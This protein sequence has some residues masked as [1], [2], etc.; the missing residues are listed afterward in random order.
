MA[1]LYKGCFNIPRI[2]QPYNPNR[3]QQH[4]RASL[5]PQI[6]AEIE[7][8][9]TVVTRNL[10]KQPIS[11]SQYSSLINETVKRVIEKR[12]NHHEEKKYNRVRK[13][14][15]Y[16]TPNSAAA[17]LNDTHN[18]SCIYSSPSPFEAQSTEFYRF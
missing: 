4:K 1:Y 8:A 15:R 7:A 16:R 12:K 10:A 14:I 13:I 5:D 17:A 11:D 9:V 18:L 6:I 2:Y 3:V